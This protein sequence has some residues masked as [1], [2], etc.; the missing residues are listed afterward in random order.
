M[1]EKRALLQIPHAPAM[2]CFTQGETSSKEKQEHHDKV[3]PRGY[4]SEYYFNMVHT[5]VSHKDMYNIQ[6]AKAVVDK[7]WTKLETKGAWY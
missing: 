7:E 5:P 6:D 4:V 3:S 1:S 2:Q